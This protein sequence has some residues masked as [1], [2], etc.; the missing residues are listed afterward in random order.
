[1]INVKLMT[2]IQ[3]NSIKTFSTYKNTTARTLK[4]K[5][6]SISTMKSCIKKKA[7]NKTSNALVKGTISMIAQRN[8]KNQLLKSF[9][10]D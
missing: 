6:K 7:T 1:M 2:R 3:Q 10:K 5:I 8:N 4:V 9:R